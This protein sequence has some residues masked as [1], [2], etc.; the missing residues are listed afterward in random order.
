MSSTRNRL[1]IL[2]V[3][4]ILSAPF[5]I[6]AGAHA[7]S[8]EPPGPQTWAVAP[9]DAEGPDGRGGFDYIVEPDDVYVD[10]VA[11][12]NLGETPLTV[13]LYAQ[14]AVQTPDNDFEVLTPDENAN[15]IGAWLQLDAAE[16]TVPARGN[17]VVPFT[18]TVPADAEPGD[19]A[20][21][22]VA[23]SILTEGE[24]STVQ[25]RVGTRMHLRVAG[26]VD[27]AIDVDTIDSRYE[28][29]WSPFATAPLDVTATL[30][31]TG[32]VRISPETQL[33][34]SGIFGWWSADATLDGAG[35]ILPEGAQSAASR[36]EGVPPI[37]PLWVTVDVVEVDSAGQDV[38]EITA[39][40]SRT[41]VV[42]AVPWVLVIVVVLLLGA[43]VIAIVNLR[44][45]AVV[46]RSE[47][48]T[49]T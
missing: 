9:A 16:V 11:I 29:R 38:T 42:W 21:G 2:A 25:Y 3:L 49:E 10:H 19:H 48:M 28:T 27:A 36:I 39:V 14:D 6:P 5:L 18:I 37:G 44:R 47:I 32:N 12:R 20:G 13:S 17:A 24:G 8:D 4:S 34:V 45:R 30:V 33:R 46:R 26:P 41:V 15:R 22:I 43:I 23:V 40:T 1:S 7:A 31:N 35:E